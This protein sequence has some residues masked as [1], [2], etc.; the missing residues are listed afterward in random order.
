MLWFVPP[1][2]CDPFDTI[3]LYRLGILG[4]TYHYTTSR[5]SREK[6]EQYQAIYHDEVSRLNP[7]IENNSPHALV[8][9]SPDDT[10]IRSVEE[11][12]FTHFRHWNLYDAMFHTSYVASKLG[13]WKERGQKRLAGLLAKMGL[14]VIL[15]YETLLNLLVDSPL[16]RRSS[17]TNT[18]MLI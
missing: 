10:S 6:Y 8:A 7:P 15:L 2:I 9:T 13:L 17:R 16:H 4:L 18:W 12:R 3:L 1:K 11:L 14:V 5:L